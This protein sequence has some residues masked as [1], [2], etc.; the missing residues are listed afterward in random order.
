MSATGR[1]FQVEYPSITLH[2]IS[3]AE[4]G[5]SIYCQ[6][7]DI[8]ESPEDA[9]EEAESELKELIIVPKDGQA[10]ASFTP[11]AK[12]CFSIL[13]AF[14]LLQW[15][16]YSRAYRY[17]PPYTLILRPLT[18]IWTTMPLLTQMKTVSTHSRAA[19]MRNSAKSGGCAV[20]S[21]TITV[22]LHT[23]RRFLPGGSRP[24]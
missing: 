10:C 1:G 21:S 9:A 19:K 23:R 8:A 7:D 16:L 4:S 2:A 18:R 20:I 24:P 11:P 13:I 15:N 17:V 12:A 3:R 5:P 6:L 14:S 22:T